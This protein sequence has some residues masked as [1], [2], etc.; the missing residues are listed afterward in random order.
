MCVTMRTRLIIIFFFKEENV[1]ILY[2]GSLHCGKLGLRKMLG[3]I[4][5]LISLFNL[6]IFSVNNVCNM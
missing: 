3:Y 6:Y 2:A 5:S 4:Y 1:L